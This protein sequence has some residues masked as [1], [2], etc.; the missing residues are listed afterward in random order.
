[1]EVEVVEKIS[2]KTSWQIEPLYNVATAKKKKFYSVKA[3]DYFHGRELNG[4]I[5]RLLVK[6]ILI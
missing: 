5:V 1:M 3:V 4:Y 6:T 2:T